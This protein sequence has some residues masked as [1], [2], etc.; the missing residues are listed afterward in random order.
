M[1][2]KLTDN[3]AFAS[4][5]QRLYNAKAFSLFK[6]KL[7]KKKKKSFSLASKPLSETYVNNPQV[8]TSVMAQNAYH[9]TVEI[10]VVVHKIGEID[11]MS[12][13]F[14]AEI[15]LEASWHDPFL[16]EYEQYNLKNNWNPHIFIMNYKDNL[17]Q[18]IWYSE[19]D[20][21]R[22]QQMALEQEHDDVGC[23]IT[24][25]RHV[26][27]TFCH[28]LDLKDFPADI[29][30]I[31]LIVST[32][33]DSN[34]ISLVHNTVNP[35]A[36]NM[37]CFLDHQEWDLFNI[38]DVANG[39]HRRFVSNESLPCLEFSIYTARKPSFY[40]W[41]SFF[42]IFLIAISSLTIFSIECDL[43]QNRLQTSCTLL[44]TCVTFKWITN[45]SLP[46]LAYMTIWDRYSLVCIL[47][48]CLQCIWHGM[49]GL[50]VPTGNAC[51]HTYF[52]YDAS[53]FFTFTAMLLFL[54][55][56]FYYYFVRISMYK[57]NEMKNREIIYVDRI[58]ETNIGQ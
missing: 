5:Q 52:A 32:I 27:G 47:I 2:Q 31:K 36:I 53:A 35:S 55:I 57:R 26:Y 49:I 1:D 22:R 40:Y 44:L 54:N 33:H 29:Q 51:I 13:K 7:K 28:K 34:R 41:N 58:I 12:G 56:Y 46:N 19:C 43:T 30:N 21:D 20:A 37:N 8:C 50:V 24:E 15:L 39:L 17:K 9:Y 18:R 48:I 14:Y 25:R 16:R 10:R 4:I 38:V 11:T 42:L 3:V 23:L 45:R 6:M